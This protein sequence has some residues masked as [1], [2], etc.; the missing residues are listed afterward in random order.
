MEECTQMR[1][2]QTDMAMPQSKIYQDNTWPTKVRC[3][4]SHSK[5]IITLIVVLTGQ[6]AIQ[7]GYRF[8]IKFHEESKNL[9]Y[10]YFRW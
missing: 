10:F 9:L 3:E 1:N 8:H 5:K 7:Y 2:H 4:N 6:S